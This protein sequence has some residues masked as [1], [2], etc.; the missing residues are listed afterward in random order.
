MKWWEW[1]VR[2]T[3]DFH[4]TGELLRTS[5]TFTPRPQVVERFADSRMGGCSLAGRREGLSAKGHWRRR[6]DKH[7]KMWRCTTLYVIADD[8]CVGGFSTQLYGL[9]RLVVPGSNAWWTVVTENTPFR[10]PQ[11]LR[12]LCH[13]N[14]RQHSWTYDNTRRLMLYKTWHCWLE[15]AGFTLVNLRLSLAAWVCVWLWL[16]PSV[17]MLACLCGCSNWRGLRQRFK[18]HLRLLCTV[19][20]SAL[21]PLGRFLMTE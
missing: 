17:C 16:P 1:D 10:L 13:V 2:H 20:N 6:R 15:I 4:W 3:V 14:V 19:A 8:Q 5:I 11:S 21:T 7:I 12:P 9:S 18:S